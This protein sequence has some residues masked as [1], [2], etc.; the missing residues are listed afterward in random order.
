MKR[1]FI[2]TFDDD[3][4]G[5]EKDIEELERKYGAEEVFGEVIEKDKVLSYINRMR[6]SG[7]GKSKSL[8]FL[9]KFVINS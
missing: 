9:E 4:K 8:E 2:V 5:A 6:N 3:I 7:S 1:K